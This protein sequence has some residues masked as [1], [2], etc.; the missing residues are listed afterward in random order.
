M[1]NED[2]SL[3]L[4]SSVLDAAQ[5]EGADAVVTVCPLCYI[6]LDTYRTKMNSKR[7]KDKQL[8]IPV[9]HFP[10]VLALALGV[11]AEKLGF[12][13]HIASVENVLKKLK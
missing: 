7:S 12:N 9:L 2:A 10:Q 11:P 13:R 8:K 6:A 3:K 1:A 4:S 5:E